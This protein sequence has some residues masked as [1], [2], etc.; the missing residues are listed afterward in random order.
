MKGVDCGDKVSERAMKCALSARI[1][2]VLE[3]GKGDGR[4][5]ALNE[6]GAV[7]ADASTIRERFARHQS[8]A[9]SCYVVSALTVLSDSRILSVT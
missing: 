1:L 2:R 6:S 7:D 9:V 8:C 5:T 4:E 3:D